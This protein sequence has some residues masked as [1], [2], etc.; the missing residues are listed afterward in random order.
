MGLFVCALVIGAASFAT[1]GVPDLEESTASLA[2]GGTE[3]LTLFVLP[4]GAGSAF[5]AA[6]TPTGV[7]E[8]ATITLIVRDGNGVVIAGF[9]AEDSW[10]E[11]AD[12]GMVPCTG[13][14]TSDQDTNVNGVTGWATALAAGGNSEDVCLVKIS[15]DALTSNGGLALNFNSA[16]MNGDGLV[17][18]AD[19]GAFSTAYYSGLNP[20]AADFQRNGA[21]DLGDIGLLAQGQGAACP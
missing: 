19:I 9:P 6:K 14:S 3:A 18:L 13:G 7:T 8:D 21:V 20:F 2:Y 12:A 16:D 1:A 4:N 10:L 15:G 5:A 17:N 11:S